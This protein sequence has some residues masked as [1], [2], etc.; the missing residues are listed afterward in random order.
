MADG[1]KN[2]ETRIGSFLFDLL[3]GRTYTKLVETVG[4]IRIPTVFRSSLYGLFCR[5]YGI[6]RSEIDG[7][8]VDFE[9]FD[10]FF[11]RKNKKGVREIRPE[12]H[13]ALCPSDSE[14]LGTSRVGNGMMVQTKGILYSAEDFLTSHR[15]AE[16]FDGGEVLTLYL[17]PRDYHRVHFPVSGVVE[18][19]HYVPGYRYPV[20]PP[21]VAFVEGLYA[22]N[23]RVV[24]V[25]KTPSFGRVITVMVAALGVGNI[26]LSW[27]PEGSY[28][29]GGSLGGRISCLENI[30]VKAGDELGIFH[31]GSTVVLMFGPEKIRLQPLRI[32]ERVQVGRILGERV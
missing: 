9:S 29:T 6:E 3:P 28:V 19:V 27:S 20:N 8:L 5:M 13:L 11:T 30:H 15:L 14:L 32:G 12:D 1:R 4:K 2:I 17:R 21:A 10:S 18:E 16:E 22:K 7:Q 31:L 26:S 23:E 24:V 25:Q